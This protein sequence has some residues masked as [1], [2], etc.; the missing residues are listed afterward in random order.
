MKGAP[1]VENL[2]RRATGEGRESETAAIFWLKTRA[3]W[4]EVNTHEHVG[5][6]H[7]DTAIT[8]TISAHEGAIKQ[9]G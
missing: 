9:L 6:L 3:R 7:Q 4:R 8:V 1:S 2:F 5:S